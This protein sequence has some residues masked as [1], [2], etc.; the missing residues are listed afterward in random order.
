MKHILPIM[1]M[2]T[3]KIGAMEDSIVSNSHSNTHPISASYSS[4]QND[5]QRLLG[6]IKIS[7]ENYKKCGE[8]LISAVEKLTVSPKACN[9]LTKIEHMHGTIELSLQNETPT[10]GRWTKSMRTISIGAKFTANILDFCEIFLWELCNAENELLEIPTTLIRITDE[11]IHSF[12]TEASE[13]HSALRRNEILKDFFDTAKRIPELKEFLESESN[14]KMGIDD[15]S[16]GLISEYENFMDYWAKVN[17]K[18]TGS[19]VHA[20]LY[21][22]AYRNYINSYNT[23]YGCYSIAGY[24]KSCFLTSKDPLGNNAE[25]LIVYAFSQKSFEL[26]KWEQRYLSQTQSANLTQPRGKLLADVLLE[27]RNDQLIRLL[28]GLYIWSQSR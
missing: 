24:D 16:D 23:Y 2:I 5:S 21:R 18:K 28:F 14:P 6:C 12:L 1:M 9:L 20:D 10:R 11:D 13:Y 7:N 26:A 25:S 22:E 8:K 4:S 17:M 3:L 15:M 19:P 27:R